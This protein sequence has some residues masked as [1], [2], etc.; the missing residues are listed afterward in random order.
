[1]LTGSRIAS[2]AQPSAVAVTVD[3]HSH[4]WR[5]PDFA[6]DLRRAGVNVVAMVASADRLLRT[7]DGGR[8]RALGTAAPGALYTD[9]VEQ[10]TTI[11][12]AIE[13]DDL[14]LVRTPADAERARDTRVPGI[15]VGCEGADMLEGSL[16]RLR[17]LYSIGVRL[18][19]LVHFRVNELGDIQT[20]APVHNGLT[21]LGADAIRACN[22]LGIIVDVAHATFDATTQAARITTRPLLLSHTFLRESPRRFT[23]GVLRDHALAVAATGGV[24]GVVPFP[25]VSATLPDYAAGIV[26]MVD[27]IGIDHVGIGGDLA[28]IRGAPPYRRFEQFPALMQILR[29]HGLSSE[30]VA[31]I[32][33]GNFMRL[34]AAVA[35]LG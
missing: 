24:V 4:A 32:A 34:F 18:I 13:R 8:A 31:K 10:L 21:P 9:T 11:V 16:E 2:A 19:Q 23:R 7:R 1:M 17:E 14:M 20:E 15:V 12:Q 35:A 3:I 25:A 30:E 6:T 28:G 5:R 27:A 22:R 29:G 33:G 26:R